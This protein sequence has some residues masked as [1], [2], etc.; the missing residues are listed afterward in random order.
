MLVQPSPAQ[1]PQTIP[2]PQPY[3]GYGSASGTSVSTQMAYNVPMANLGPASRYPHAFDG[4]NIGDTSVPPSPHPEYGGYASFPS[5]APV[6]SSS[7]Q[8]QHHTAYSSRPQSAM[9]SPVQTG[10]G[11]GGYFDIQRPDPSSYPT[12]PSYGHPAGPDAYMKH[13]V[14][15][16]SYSTLSYG[17]DP[18]TVSGSSMSNWQDPQTAPGQAQQPPLQHHYSTWQSHGYQQ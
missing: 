10:M 13:G 5:P 4:G 18:G 15:P 17:P 6:Q 12:S 3:H 14:P 7:Y 9:A 16:S 8:Q 11:P 1:P 2:P